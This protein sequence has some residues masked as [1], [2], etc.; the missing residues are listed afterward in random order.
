MTMST[1]TLL[2]R[3]TLIPLVRQIDQRL[4]QVLEPFDGAPGV[5][6]EAMR[7]CVFSGGKRFRPL[8]CLGGCLAVGGDVR[9]A[10][11]VACAIELIHTYSLVHDDLP[12]MDNADERRGRPSCH[13]RFGESLAILTGDALLTKAFELL[14]SERIPHALAILRTI[15]QASGTTGLIGGQVLDLSV[16]PFARSPVRPFAGKRI[17][18]PTRQPANPPTTPS[19]LEDIATRKTAALMTASVVAG[20]L[21]GHASASA[22]ARLKRYG[23]SVGLAFQLKDDLHDQ[24]GLVRAVGDEAVSRK[25]TR[26]IEDATRTLDPLGKPAWILRELA[27]WLARS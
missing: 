24:D 5:L 22:L 16:S 10:L 4:T 26:L 15:A 6:Q 21:V 12:A 18:P 2:Q 13:R 25:A 20:G 9:K 11:P 27:E 17:N 3:N 14:S 19:S 8:L 7:Y 23:A 1:T